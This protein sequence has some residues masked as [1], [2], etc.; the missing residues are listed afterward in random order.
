MDDFNLDEILDDEAVDLSNY[1]WVHD[2]A[3]LGNPERDLSIPF[4]TTEYEE[5][6]TLGYATFRGTRDELR[7]WRT[8]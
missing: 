4:T 6:F 7:V 5:V 2:H 3:V 8:E 1:H